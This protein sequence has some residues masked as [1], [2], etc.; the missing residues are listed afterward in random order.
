[1][2]EDTVILMHVINTVNPCTPPLLWKGIIIANRLSSLES[3]SALHHT[4]DI[5]TN[6]MLKV[7]FLV[8]H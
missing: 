4:H 2:Y 8:Y 7:S 6:A 1:M 3:T 5:L